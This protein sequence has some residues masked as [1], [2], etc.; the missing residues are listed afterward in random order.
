VH[1]LDEDGRVR[2][3]LMVNMEGR[4][5]AAREILAEDWEHSPGDLVSRIA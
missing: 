1:Y 3:V 4:L 5:D 2:G